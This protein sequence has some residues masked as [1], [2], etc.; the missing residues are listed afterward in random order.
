MRGK[1][2]FFIHS[3][4]EF[5]AP[6]CTWSVPMTCCPYGT[7]DSKKSRR[8]SM[9]PEASRMVLP[10]STEHLSLLLRISS[11]WTRQIAEP[12]WSSAAV[13]YSLDR[14]YILRSHLRLVLLAFP[15]F[16]A[17]ESHNQTNAIRRT[18]WKKICFCWA[19]TRP[20]LSHFSLRV[21]TLSP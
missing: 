19:P 4:R 16:T 14:K 12:S 8:N 7:Q 21:Q 11:Q 18:A 6:H 20:K 5:V 3:G 17:T 15:H 13:A 2:C 9:F 1:H 10:S